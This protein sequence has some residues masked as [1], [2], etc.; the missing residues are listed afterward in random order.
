MQPLYDAIMSLGRSADDARHGGWI[1]GALGSYTGPK[2]VN[3]LV[4]MHLTWPTKFYNNGPVAIAN[5]QLLG[6]V[7]YI[8]NLPPDAREAG[9]IAGIAL[10]KTRPTEYDKTVLA[11]YDEG[12]GKVESLLSNPDQGSLGLLGNV[13]ATI[14]D[15]EEYD[16][17][18]VL[19]ATE[20]AA[21]FD[22]AFEL[23]AAELPDPIEAEALR[24]SAPVAT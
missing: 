1:C 17:T 15:I 3:G 23:L 16:E 6:E 22:R 11:L 24:V 13:L 14:N 12:K 19:G 7:T 2:C 10:I 21:W 8:E 20:A 5:P 9:R 18:A 4:T